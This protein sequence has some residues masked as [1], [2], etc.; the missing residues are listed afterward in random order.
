[1]IPIVSGSWLI[2]KI[3]D[4]SDVVKEGYRMIASQF[5]KFSYSEL[6]KATNNFK[7]LG[8][9]ASGVVFKGVLADERVVA[10]K[11][12]EDAH[13]LLVYEYVENQSLDKHFFSQEKLLDGKRGLKLP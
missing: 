6:R 11:K 9:E 5:R 4:V 2:F 12:L 7:E 13:R 1:M 10:V 3:H 8:K